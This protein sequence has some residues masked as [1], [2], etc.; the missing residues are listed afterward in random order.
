MEKP[1]TRAQPS[2][3]AL[4]EPRAKMNQ[5]ILEQL[6]TLDPTHPEYPAKYPFENIYEAAGGKPEIYPL[7]HAIAVAL[8]SDP[9]DRYPH[10]RFL[11][12]KFV[13]KGREITPEIQELKDDLKR[14]VRQTLLKRGEKK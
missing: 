3:K 11:E 14:R 9:Q 1:P 2:T 12:K 10:L 13:L 8:I 7:K 4:I 5:Q 6:L